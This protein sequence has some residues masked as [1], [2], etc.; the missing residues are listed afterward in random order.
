M[1]HWLI[2]PIVLPAL[3]ATVIL[4]FLRGR[5]L[6]LARYVSLGAS[7]AWVAL[8]AT[9]VA[10]AS[11]GAI[12]TYALGNW[13]APFGIVLVLDRLSAV[14][15]LL[16]A[17]LG[18]AVSLYAAASDLDRKGWHFH[19]LFHLQIVGLNGAFLT[20]DLFNLFVFF[21]M[22]LIA[23]YG[24]MLHGQGPARLKAGVQY[25]VVNLAGSTLF[26]VAVGILY[27]VTG[28]L[29]MADMAMK[30]AAA[31]AG[32][33]ALIHAGGLLLITVFALKAALFPLHLW[34][35][36]TYAGTSA[37]V[38]A[39]F[40]IMTK[41]GA[42]A[43]VR[44]TTLVFGA[45]AG[46]A[47]WAPAAWL[48]PAALVTLVL[49]FVGVLSARSLRDLA[50]FGVVGSMGTLLAAVSVFQPEAIT[51]ALYYTLHA[52]LAGA[53]LFLTADLV[54]RRRGDHGDA[55]TPGPRF[56]QVE[57]LSVLYFLAAIAVVGLPPLSGFLG[58]LFIL[59]AVRPSAHGA[60]IWGFILG[61]TVVS[62][63]GFARAGSTLF[64]ESAEGPHAS[65][66]KVPVHPELTLGITAALL[67]GLGGLTVMAG[68]VTAYL[69]AASAQLFD[70]KAYLGAVLGAR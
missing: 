34:L 55:L 48:L 19:S 11:T 28:T 16:A 40:V 67:V 4:L 46:E 23:S 41:V 36:R 38:A 14:M 42:Y 7:A 52:T 53:A 43:I 8:G 20:G 3:T 45:S 69:G 62:L 65:H 9:L 61:T 59:D 54:G 17:V 18:L 13:P 26:L 37:P 44:V 50:A 31:P 30:V 70:T 29:N 56:P 58:K 68:P 5:R 63:V 47:A 2:A 51:A 57:V 49:G 66:C 60:W 15:V 12:E 25:V 39:L 22:L 10:R 35:P 27:G 33:E 6:R 21:E 32:D 24:L 64:W 1:T